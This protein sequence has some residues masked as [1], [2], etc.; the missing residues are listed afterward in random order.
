[1]L[2]ESH[3]LAHE[4]RVSLR[5]LAGEPFILFPRHLSPRYYDRIAA[6]CLDQG[7]F[8]LSVAQESD[9]IQTTLGLVAAGLGVSLQPDSVRNLGRLGVVYRP[10]VEPTPLVETGIAYR[11]GDRS[12]ILRGLLG[13]VRELEG[14]L[15]RLP[16]ST[17]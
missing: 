7:G 1:V 13:V 11:K 14:T 15:R 8:T 16:P 2:P 17:R 12:E 6:M 3:A 4:E 9:T 5:Q 10:L